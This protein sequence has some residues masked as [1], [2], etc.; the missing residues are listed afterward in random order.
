MSS[1][2][3]GHPP[4]VA[5]ALA[6]VIDRALNV[7][8]APSMARMAEAGDMAGMRRLYRQCVRRAAFMVASVAVLLMAAFYA[9]GDTRTPV[10][11][12]VS[13]FLI[14]LVLESLAFLWLG[15]L[16]LAAATS[17]YYVANLLILSAPLEKRIR[18]QVS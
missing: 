9:L 15:L 6:T 13:G 17:V 18:V 2:S 5:G 14:G 11:I 16:G 1:Q 7:P 8:A 12:G 10:T 3:S 4:A